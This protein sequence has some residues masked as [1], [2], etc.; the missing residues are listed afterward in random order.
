MGGFLA[1]YWL[2][3]QTCLSCLVDRSINVRYRAPNNQCNVT[4]SGKPREAID[5]YTHARDWDAA[6]RVAEQHAPDAAPDVLSAQVKRDE[7]L[8]Y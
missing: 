7:P 2:T 8:Q 3:L 4:L 6:L 5:M 1:N